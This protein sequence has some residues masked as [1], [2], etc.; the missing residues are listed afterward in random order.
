MHLSVYN[1][2]NIRE[3]PKCQTFFFILFFR[4]S[5]PFFFCSRLF[6]FHKIKYRSLASLKKSQRNKIFVLFLFTIVITSYLAKVSCWFLFLVEQ[7]EHHLS[8]TAKLQM[9]LS[10]GSQRT[11][12]PLG[13]KCAINH[14][15]TAR[16]L[17][18]SLSQRVIKRINGSL[19]SPNYAHHSLPSF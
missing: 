7:G 8:F 12:K 9:W 11:T 16:R 17:S 13:I 1:N 18:F 19:A 6:S 4:W 2:R 15:S 5:L 10:Q 14:K 3:T